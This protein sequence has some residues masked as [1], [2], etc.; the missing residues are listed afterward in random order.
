MKKVLK[1]IVN[2]DILISCVALVILIAVTFSNA[3]LRYFFNAP[4]QWGEEVQMILIV[5][6]I[7]FGG[8]C[9]FRTGNQICVD[10]L[11]GLL[12]K[13]MQKVIHV[14]IFLIS[15]AVLAFL[16]VQGIAYVEQLADTNR[17]TETLHIPRVVVYS[18]MPVSC[19]LMIGNMAYGFVKEWKGEEQGNE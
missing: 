16:M 1:M 6:L 2:L 8:S 4:Y 11:L 5:W 17:I 9:A 18:C 19:L 10:I 3:I 13:G 12:P 15:A 14:V 7:W